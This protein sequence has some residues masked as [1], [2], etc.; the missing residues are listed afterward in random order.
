MEKLL[1]NFI[2]QYYFYKDIV[3]HYYHYG[4]FYKLANSPFSSKS[5]Q[6]IPKVIHYC[7]F[8]R[9]KM[10][11]LIKRCMNSWQEFLPEYK[12]VLWNEDNFPMDDYPFAKQALTDHKWAFVSDVARLHALFYH[13][14]IYMD[15]DVEVLKPLNEAFFKYGFFSSFESKIHIPTG[16]MGAQKGNKYVYML[17]GWYI[18]RDLNRR[19]YKIANTRIITKLTCMYA[20]LKRDGTLQHFNDCI[21]YPRD[22][23]CPEKTADGWKSTENTYTIHHFTGTW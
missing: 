1:D 17:L 5:N 6:T 4:R 8:G 12:L 9:G 2:Q 19:Y 13:G 20:N 14:G 15:T 7:W 21:Y 23:F 10:N 22:Y 3:E 18:N 16:L 11:D